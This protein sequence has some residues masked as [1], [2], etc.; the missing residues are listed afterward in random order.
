MSIFTVA[1]LNRYLAVQLRQDKRLQGIFVRGEIAD[2]HC[3][4]RSGHCYFTLRDDTAAM[5][6]VMFAGAAERL[7]F[8]PAN[9]MTVIAAGSITVYE[10]DGVYQLNVTDLQPDG[11]GAAH[12]A[13][14]QRKEKLAAL[15]YFDEARKRALPQFPKRIGVVTAPGGAALQDI[16]HILSRR[17]P[18]A[19][20]QLFPVLV[21]GA[22]APK[23]ISSAI[24]RASD[25]GCDVLIVGRGGGSN[26][27]LSAFDE[28][29]VATAI[30]RCKIPVISAV[31]HETDVSIADYTAD[32]RASTPSAA[33]ELAAPEIS[34]LRAALSGLEQSMHVQMRRSIA[35]LETMLSDRQAAL[36]RNSVT[37]RLERM[38]ER[39]SQLTARLDAAMSAQLRAREQ[40]FAQRIAQL[41]C[42]SPLKVMLRGYALVYKDDEILSSVQNVRQDDILKIR[43]ADGEITAAVKEVR[44]SEE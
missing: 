8:L 17:Y 10:R 11:V 24:D 42:L 44:S 15:G 30:F 21:Q 26:E 38:E 37:G 19:T 9:G 34:M 28:E 13:L 36:E 27:D 35:G 32:L 25:S 12:L 5:K 20:V 29:C 43:L 41:D 16:L 23:S 3:H 39:R 33:A 2:F 40:E 31:G 18:I 4:P 22:D 7:R 6:A 1:N 14:K